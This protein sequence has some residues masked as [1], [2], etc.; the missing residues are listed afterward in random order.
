MKENGYFVSHSQK[1][2]GAAAA[3]GFLPRAGRSMGAAA[4]L[5]ALTMG[6]A[7]MGQNP[8]TADPMPAP[9]AHV[10][11]PDGYALHQS[12]DVGGRMSNVAG[13]GAMYDS[14]VNLHAGPR[15]LGETFELRALPGRK[16]TLVD[17][18]EAFSSGYG[19]DPN[20]V[21][22]L[23]FS[24]NRVYEFSGL[25]RRDRQYFDYDLLGNPNIPPGQSIAVGA[26]GSLA[27]PL[28]T[29]S[30]VEFNTVRRMT[31]TSLALRP[32]AKVSFRAGYAENVFAG[33]SLSPGVSSNFFA[34]SI[35]AT[36]QLL[37]QVERSSTDEFLGAI[38]WKPVASTRLTF[39]EV[40]NHMK[41]DT[42]FTL[43]PGTFLVQE[44]DGTPVSL[45][46]WDSLT[47]YSAFNCNANS[48]GSAP[49]L[50]AAQTPGGKPVVNPACAVAVSYLR[51]EP[52]R[53]L[54]PTEVFRFESS[55]L[56]NVA[57]NGEAR[58][59]QANLNLP[60]YYENFAGL[61]GTAHAITYTGFGSARRETMA[62]DFGLVWQ[63]SPSVELAEQVD[64]SNVH[65]PGTD[66]T[67]LG[68]TLNTPATAGSE[69][70]NYT[71]PLAPG[72]P[73]HVEGS[74]NG[75]PLP[76]YFGLK[77]LTN[78]LTL[79]WMAAPRATFTLSYRYRTRTIAEGLPHA[80][81]LAVGATSNGTVAIDENG[82]VFGVALRPASDWSLNASVE[83]LFAD[84][85]FTPLGA[86]QTEHYRV[87][88]RYRPR[89]WATVS[90]AFNDLER[91]NNTNNN[92]S[93]VGDTSYAGPLAHVDHSRFFSLGASL[94]PS[95]RYGFDFNYAY[96]DVYTST[97]ICY[98]AA[99]SG[100][101]PG[102]ATP[103]GTACPGGTVLFASY[104][105]FGPVKDFMDAPTQ[106]AFA[107]FTFA[108]VKALRTSF[109][110]RISAVDGS[111][112]FNDARA[113]NGSLD[114]TFQTPYVNLAWTVRH[115]WIWSAEYSY[116]GYGEGGVSGA[117]YCSLANPTPAAPAPVVPCSSLAFPTGRTEP[118][119][120][121]S[122]P[123]N[124]HANNVTAG[125]HYEF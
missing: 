96:S 91:R 53:I 78:N 27:W 97:N 99:A 102:A 94:A 77:Y 10:T 79:S 120:G 30:P 20:N 52:T 85:A 35:G 34:E 86:R 62:A 64:F 73:G 105:M 2:P 44:A 16:G 43:W 9:A 116:S 18:L 12:I 15:V 21:A 6:I 66:Y 26:A 104:Y 118:P 28:V 68:N 111:Q 124:F 51:S 38:D 101:L 92:Q 80:A 107:A 39:E 8:T 59:T 50:S 37:E 112:F 125:M 36:D 98:N 60:H 48:M 33:P 40:V 47:P 17:T 76:D 121:L 83:G 58:Y 110:E 106:S 55:S 13:S 109:G 11:V 32:L 45:G 122:A 115:G 82:G 119:A 54:F 46:G 19:G 113:V 123:R 84:N 81:P 87:H 65:Q 69:T 4:A 57:L 23:S 117:E 56:K 100:T 88:T 42:Y 70:I 5:C 7:A 72:T 1:R 61:D 22:R 14:L 3:P 29:Q 25:F 67:S 49:L 24:K 103:T 93:A 108:P 74:P 95:E 31:D 89:P 41:A 75:A 71:G 114:S 90:A 63:A